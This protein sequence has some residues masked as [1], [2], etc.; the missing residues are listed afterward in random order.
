MTTPL[1]RSRTLL[2]GVSLT[3]LVILAAVLAPV[4]SPADPNS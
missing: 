4:L 2:A 3:G 1:L